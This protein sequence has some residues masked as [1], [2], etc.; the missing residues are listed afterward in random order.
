LLG[1]PIAIDME[2]GVACL[3]ASAA[4]RAARLSSLEA[5]DFSLPDIEG[6]PHALSDYRGTKVVLVAYASW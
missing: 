2:E 6:R 4:E 3:G 5:P 1:R